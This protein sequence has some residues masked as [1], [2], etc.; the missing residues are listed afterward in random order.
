V[1]TQHCLN[2]CNTALCYASLLL[3]FNASP[4]EKGRKNTDSGCGT[5]EFVTARDTEYTEELATGRATEYMEEFVTG[6]SHR[7][8]LREPPSE[9]RTLRPPSETWLQAKRSRRTLHHLKSLRYHHTLSVY[10]TDSWDNTTLSIDKTDSDYIDCQTTQLVKWVIH[11]SITP[12]TGCQT[13]WC[14]GE[15]ESEWMK[16]L[17]LTYWT[18]VA[19]TASP[20]QKGRNQVRKSLKR[21]PSTNRREEKHP[22]SCWASWERRWYSLTSTVEL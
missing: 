18:D 8:W 12:T 1:V 15:I 10:Q 5:K 22:K 6:E 17:E 4:Q 11:T 7:L 9:A 3:Y 14:Q 2:Y 20:Q 21:T 16:E 19:Y 13:V